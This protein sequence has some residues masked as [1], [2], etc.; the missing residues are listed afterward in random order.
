MLSCNDAQGQELVRRNHTGIDPY[1]A[2]HIALVA[3]GC[4]R[5]TQ[6]DDTLS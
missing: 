1:E 4:E 6:V 2:L 5:E 3:E